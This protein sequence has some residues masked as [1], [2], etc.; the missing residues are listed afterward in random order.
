MI[1]RSMSESGSDLTCLSVN[2]VCES[3]S[4]LTCLSD[5]AGI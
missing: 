2:A 4:D 3:V 5:E 1:R